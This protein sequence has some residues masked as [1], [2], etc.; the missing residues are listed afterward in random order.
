MDL[1]IIILGTMLW[2]FTL[3]PISPRLFAFIC[4]DV[5]H[6]CLTKT[7]EFRIDHRIVCVFIPTCVITRQY[8]VACALHIAFI[9]MKGSIKWYPLQLSGIVL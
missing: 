4:H 8:E 2:V 1:H 7:S 9:N 6:R 5:R 3:L